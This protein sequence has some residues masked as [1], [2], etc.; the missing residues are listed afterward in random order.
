MNDLSEDDGT[1]YGNETRP[2][3]FKAK[4]RKSVE[5]KSKPKSV[6][7]QT[8]WP[9]RHNNNGKPKWGDHISKHKL[10]S[11]CSEKTCGASR[12]LSRPIT[13]TTARTTG[14]DNIKWTGCTMMVVLIPPVYTQSSVVVVV[15]LECS[16][17]IHLLNIFNLEGELLWWQW[18]SFRRG[19]E[20]AVNSQGHTADQRGRWRIDNATM[21]KRRWGRVG[22]L[23]RFSLPNEKAIELISFLPVP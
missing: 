9:R 19:S 20:W 23:K 1:F 17:S 8:N 5:D 4:V 22:K 11:F 6:N 14:N 2:R 21:R 3:G 7:R 13:K 10:S 12:T 18:S 15:V 16:C